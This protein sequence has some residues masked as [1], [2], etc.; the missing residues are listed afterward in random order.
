[1]A[2]YYQNRQNESEP[3][4]VND[5]LSLNKQHESSYIIINDHILPNKQNKFVAIIYIFH[6]FRVNTLYEL[7]NYII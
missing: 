4:I 3:I 1:M 2:S 5:Q 6:H 7:L